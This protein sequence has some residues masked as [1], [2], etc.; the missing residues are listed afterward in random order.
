MEAA[1]FP[2]NSVVASYLSVEKMLGDVLQVVPY[3]PSHENV[4]SPALVTVLLESCSQLESLW[5]FEAKQSPCVPRKDLHI[6][7]YFGYFGEALAYRWLVFWGEEPKQLRPYKRW[8][9]IKHYTKANYVPLEW[10]QAYNCLKHDRLQN[11]REATIKRAA[12]SLAALFLNILRCEF[13]RDYVAA[14]GWLSAAPDVAH[15]PSAHLGEDSAST[16]K[17][18]VLAESKFFSYPVGWCK[19]AIGKNKCWSGNGS[20]RFKKW[21]DAH[22][23]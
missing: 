21:F 1:V 6:K 2:G 19:D 15:N 10:W 14:A 23:S 9:S 22:Y 17:S 13:C 7:D 3:C 16:W 4:W 18:Y 12:Q 20:I 11:R 8:A 5:H